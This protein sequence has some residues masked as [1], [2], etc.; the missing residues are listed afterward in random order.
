MAGSHHSR[1]A[2]PTAG[3]VQFDM[4]GFR[5][6]LAVD[7]GGTIVSSATGRVQRALAPVGPQ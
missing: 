7:G 5:K 1:A 3:R 4:R 6:V 2:R